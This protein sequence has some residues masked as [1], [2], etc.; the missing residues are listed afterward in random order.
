MSRLV[1]RPGLQVHWHVNRLRIRYL[2]FIWILA[3]TAC[4]P[5]TQVPLPTPTATNTPT[6]GLLPIATDT[7]AITTVPSPSVTPTPVISLCSPLSITPWDDLWKIDWQAFKMPNHYDGT[8]FRDNGH[9]GVDLVYFSRYGRPSIMGEGVQS[10]MDGKIA[11][12]IKDRNPYGN[13]VMTETSYDRIP[14]LLL[15]LVPIPQG[16]SLYIVYA[17]LR[18]FPSLSVGDSVNCGQSLG[19]VGM[20]GMATGPHLHFEMRWGPSGSQFPSMA[21]YTSDYTDEE[22]KNYVLWRMSGSY[23]PFDPMILLS[24]RFPATTPQT[25]TGSDQ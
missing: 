12:I 16:D 15:S 11:S 21:Y 22:L 24:L 13:M 8:K 5:V 4:V 17:H 14:P 18:D 7:P 20:S 19:H 1:S 25:S 9:P 3:L 6:P 23:V 2:P 10:V